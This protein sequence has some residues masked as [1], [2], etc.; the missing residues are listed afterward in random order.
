MTRS[1]S[2][3]KAG[4]LIVE[5]MPDTSP[6]GAISARDRTGGI[7]SVPINNDPGTDQITAFIRKGKI[8]PLR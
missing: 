7:Y 1:Y 4:G 6:Q 8:T 3:T 5:D 2:R